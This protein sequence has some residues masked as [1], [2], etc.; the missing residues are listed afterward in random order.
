V[1]ARNAGREIA[2]PLE[3]REMLKLKSA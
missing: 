3:A 2:S 1:C